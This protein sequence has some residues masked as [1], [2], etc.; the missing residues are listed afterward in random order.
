MKQLASIFELVTPEM[1]EAWLVGNGHNRRLVMARVRKYANDMARGRWALNPQP[2]VIADDGTLLDGQHRLH[3]VVES[4]L[5]VMMAVVHGAPRSMQDVLDQGKSRDPRDVL[6]LNGVAGAK[7]VVST[8]RALDMLDHGLPTNNPQLSVGDIDDLRATYRVGLGWRVGAP[9]IKK[10]SSNYYFGPL[11]WVFEVA[12]GEIEAFHASVVQGDHLS[13]GDPALALRN[14]MLQTTSRG[15]WQ[16]MREMMLKVC[17]ALAASLEG[18]A[19][20]VLRVS[21]SGYDFLRSLR[22]PSTGTARRRG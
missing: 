14:W 13:V 4:G 20:Q 7:N 17:S 21:E 11:V 9:T 6:T 2:V 19:L 16:A 15:G 5:P 8:C 1:A 18:R 12:Q 10:I 3:A 22:H